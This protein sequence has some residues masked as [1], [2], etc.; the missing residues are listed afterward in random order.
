MYQ[1]FPSFFDSDKADF[2]F[3]KKIKEKD[4]VSKKI[5]ASYLDR[6]SKEENE[7]EK[8]KKVWLMANKNKLYLAKVNQVFILFFS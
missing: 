8:D 7:E 1:I 3:W 6:V 5:I 4:S 2:H